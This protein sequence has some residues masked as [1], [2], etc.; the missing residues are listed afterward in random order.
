MSQ[1]LGYLRSKFDVPLVQAVVDKLNRV[2]ACERNWLH[3]SLQMS[4]NGP[5]ETVII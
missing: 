1:D 2:D 3:M 4:P 5:I